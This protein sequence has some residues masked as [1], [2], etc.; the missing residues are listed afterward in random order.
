VVKNLD[1]IGLYL[2]KQGEGGGLISMA[3]GAELVRGHKKT[4]WKSLGVLVLVD[5]QKSRWYSGC[6][7]KKQYQPKKQPSYERIR[8]FKTLSKNEKGY[9]YRWEKASIAFRGEYPLC[10]NCE[11]HGIVTPSRLVDH[12][13]PHVGDQELFWDRDNWQALCHRCH[14]LKSDGEEGNWRVYYPINVLPAGCD[15]TIIFGSPASGKSHIAKNGGFD[16]VVDADEIA[17]CLYGVRLDA[18]AHEEQRF[19]VLGERNQQLAFLTADKGKAVFVTTSA[20]AWQKQKMVDALKPKR[21]CTLTPPISTTTERILN[22]KT[23]NHLSIDKR[24]N[25]VKDWYNNYSLLEGEIR[26]E[27]TEAVL[28]WLGESG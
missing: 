10:V 16:T 12:I 14:R 7:V 18:I 2:V 19:K 22:D 26:H 9:N 13:I 27:T 3:Y 21:W 11:A 8:E 4:H 23:R 20:K 6:M 17:M 24:V 28:Q 5:G 25:M 15:L 1:F